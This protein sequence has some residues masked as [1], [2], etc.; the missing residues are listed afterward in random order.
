MSGYIYVIIGAISYGLLSS[1]VK[2]AYHNGL[3]ASQVTLYQIF[4]G[5]LLLLIFYLFKKISNFLK[6]KKNK[7]KL[8]FKNII[9]LIVLGSTT[10][11]TGILYYLSLVNIDASLAI[12]LLFQFTW[13][14][15]VLEFIIFKV[16]PRKNQILSLI[17]I[18][19][20]TL[21]ATNIFNVDF[22]SISPLGL[23]F[24]FLSAISYS[25]FVLTSSKIGVNIPYYSKSLIMVSGGLIL[26]MLVYNPF[27]TFNAEGFKVFIDSHGILLGFLGACLCTLMFAK[28][29]PMIGPTKTAIIGTLELPTVLIAS[30]LLLGENLNFTKILG[31]LFIFLGI[32]ISNNVI[33][34]KKSL[35]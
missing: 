10:G 13:I 6:N 30:T 3:D 22:Q 26:T 14:S 19:L 18:L 25:I 2:I 34:Y 29:S 1:L 11:L 35:S 32:L 21:L 5:W 33:S 9:L 15:F 27:T 31:M 24:G 12:I 28:G 4:I 16:K 23:L 8:L 20:G 17:P 7:K